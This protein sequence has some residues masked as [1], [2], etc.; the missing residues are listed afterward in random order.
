MAQHGW[1]AKFECG[2][3]VLRCNIVS[4]TFQIHR[5]RRTLCRKGRR[6]PAL[7]PREEDKDL[8]GAID[9][10][11]VLIHGFR[12][13]DPQRLLCS[14]EAASA[15]ERRTILVAVLTTARASLHQI[16]QLRVAA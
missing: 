2:R 1:A 11:E 16:D 9:Q 5:H 8:L 13:R 14:T 12:N 15:T 6:R 4:L 10:G 7:R 3:G